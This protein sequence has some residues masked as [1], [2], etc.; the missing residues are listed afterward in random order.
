VAVDQLADASLDV[1]AGERRHGSSVRLG[2]T[3][4]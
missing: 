3:T 4:I 2:A 1:D